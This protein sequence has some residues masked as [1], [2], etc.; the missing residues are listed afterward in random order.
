MVTLASVVFCGCLAVP[1]GFRVYVSPDGCAPDGSY[2]AGHIANYYD[3]PTRTAV[4]AP[5]Q[6]PSTI[7]HEICHA[8]QHEVILETLDREPDLALTQWYL[9]GEGVDFMAMAGWN[10]DGGYNENGPTFRAYP[11]ADWLHSNPLEDA[12]W[13]CAWYLLDKGKLTPERLAWADR[14]LR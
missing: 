6:G 14:W 3:P 1:S 13:T 7:L 2:C 12:A 10:P 9:T 5:G 4:L 11:A 8:H